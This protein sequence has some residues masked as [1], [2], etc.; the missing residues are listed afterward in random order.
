MYTIFLALGVGLVVTLLPL[1]FGVSVT[2]T[3]L[4]GILFGVVAFVWVNRR[5]AKRVQA[6]IQAADAEMAGLQQIAQRPGP[7]TQKA[8]AKRFENAI[9]YLES[10]FLFS[11]WQIGIT[12]M[13]NARIGMLIYTRTMLL[14]QG[15]LGEAIPYLEKT[16][17]KGAKA[18]LLQAMWPAWAMLAVCYYKGKKDVDRAVEVLEDAVK[19]ARK[20]GLLWSLYAWILWKSKRHDEAVDVLARAREAA[21]DDKRVAENLKALQNKKSMKMR[22]YGEQ[23]YQFG[24]EKPRMA[25]MSPQMGHPRM[26][27]RGMRRR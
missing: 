13:L 3:V 6:V 10:G 8:M 4:P 23:W 15:S 27:G 16:R 18:K 24:L 2:W 11:K 9:Q 12:T 19:I 5:I 17:V 25:G 1:P 26:R 20:E 22:G 7:G 14:N 21:P